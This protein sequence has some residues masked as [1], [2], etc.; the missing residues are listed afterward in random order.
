MS[1]NQRLGRLIIFTLLATPWIGASAEE[2]LLKQF[3]LQFKGLDRSPF[4]IVPH[5][6][7]ERPLVGLALSGGGIRG[8]AQ[9]GVLQVFEEEDIPI[10]IIVGT[11]IGGVLGG[12]YA[13]GYSPSELYDM[14][15]AVD[16]GSVLS[17]APQRSS[18]FLNEKEKRGRSL[19]QF[20]I[21]RGK[22]VVP[23]AYTPG[24]KITRIFTELVLN[25]RY[26]AE[27][28][29]RLRTRLVVVAT[30][31]LTGRQ[32]LLRSGDLALAMRSTVA[33]PLLF[34][35]VESDSALLVDGGVVSN[36]PVTE[37]R[38]EGA[39]IV[40]AV[41]TTSPL[42]R[43]HELA[44]PWEIADQITTIMQQPHNR[45]QLEEADVVI[46]L[47]EFRSISSNYTALDTLYQEGVRKTRLQIDAV[48]RRFEEL[49]AGQPDTLLH[50]DRIECRGAPPSYYKDLLDTL[51]HD[52]HPGRIRL[53]LLNLYRRGDFS[54]VSA[55]VLRRTDETVLRFE[56]TLNPVLQEVVFHGNT[57]L[58][59]D[60]L[61]C[62]FE[63]LL[64]RPINVRAARS[65]FENMIGRYRSAGFSLA[66]VDRVLFDKQTGTAHIYLSEGVIQDVVITG[67][68]KTRRY[69]VNRELSFHRGDLFRMEKARSSLENIIATGL[70]STVNLHIDSRSNLH[71]VH[72]RLQ[73]RPSTLIR[74][75]L[76]FDT[77]RS[78][79]VFAELADENFRGSGDDLTAHLQY[80]GRDVR[81]AVN[82]SADRIFQS[83][84]TARFNLHHLRSSHYAYRNLRRTGEYLRI[85]SGL[86]AEV[87]RQ[88][89]RF[90]TFSAF[91]RLE[92]IDLDS[93]DG[94]GFDR[95]RMRLSTVGLKTVV[96]TR[97]QVPFATSGKHHIFFYEVSSGRILG[98]D[99]SYFKV[100]NQLATYNTFRRRHTFAPKIIWGTSDLMAPFSEQFRI[101]GQRSFLGL[102]EGQL[103][104]R[105][106]FQAGVEYRCLLRRVWTMPFY[107][108]L[109]GDMAAAWN[110]LS[111]VQKTDFISGGGV[112]FSLMT[113]A[114]PLQLAYGRARSL[115]YC[116]Y[117]SA[118]FDF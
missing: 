90:G 66:R 32:V 106:M 115:G 56:L 84:L 2:T 87:G 25:A 68:K 93:L 96:D 46:S 105:Y 40:I 99:A 65:A 98:A 79:R 20:R 13:S 109:R 50:V 41:D 3:R 73:E 71:N 53:L 39:D 9:I 63:P 49:V 74:F 24:Q 47:A 92:E 27:A 76:R 55:Q 116:F 103:W 88:M 16:W 48:R 12:L 6:I 1:V 70:F 89:E 58:C 111:A 69:V 10:D 8:I 36:I 44:A 62:F 15:R 33:L 45:R 4:C 95:G 108:S 113:P 14:A 31:M 82:Y 67:L 54:D 91:L 117:L 59:D 85:A 19:V 29:D 100:M 21:E 43:P 34:A 30:D 52:L 38:S 28:F 57:L 102:K 94:Y 11:S 35:P 80:G 77:E 114:G 83:L 107:L 23:E 72:L 5:R 37:T 81:A 61:R 22:P 42:R 112:E 26:H 60:S 78:A 51:G 110:R 104:G 18:L 118:G 101:G 97:D 7:P 64:Q 17:D 86:E 75:G